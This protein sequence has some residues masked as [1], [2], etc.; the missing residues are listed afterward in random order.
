[1][2][3]NSASENRLRFLGHCLLNCL[4]VLPEYNTAIIVVNKQDLQK[5]NVNTGDTEGIVN[6]ALS[7]ASIRLAAFIVERQDRVKLSLRSKGEFPANE[8][9][10]LYFSGGGHRNAAG[11]QSTDSLQNVVNQFKTILPEYKKLLIQ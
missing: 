5:Y 8:I 1:L 10:K 6:Y 4:E 7:M 11:G 9:C 2:V 3:Y